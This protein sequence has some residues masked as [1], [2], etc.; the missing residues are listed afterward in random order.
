MTNYQKS[1]SAC[2]LSFTNVQLTMQWFQIKYLVC[3][4]DPYE[5]YDDGVCIRSSSFLC[6]IF[7]LEKLDF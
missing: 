6:F 2:F 7:L 4:L 1:Y 3:K 5:E